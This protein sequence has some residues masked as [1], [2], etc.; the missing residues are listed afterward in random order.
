MFLLIFTAT[1]EL[2]Q[3]ILSLHGLDLSLVL[4]F[5][6]LD[7]GTASILG[8]PF[9]ELVVVDGALWELSA[10]RLLAVVVEGSVGVVELATASISTFINIALTLFPIGRAE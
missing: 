7:A 3:L 1:Q 2:Y 10:M 5:V 6:L 8:W 9:E 4:G